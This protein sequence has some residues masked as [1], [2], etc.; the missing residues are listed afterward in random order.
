MGLGVQGDMTGVGGHMHLDTQLHSQSVKYTSAF[1][2]L[3]CTKT[4]HMHIV[5]Q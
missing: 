1:S 2:V 5:I 4:C 3:L